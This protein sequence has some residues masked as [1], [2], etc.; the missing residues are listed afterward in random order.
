MEEK[1]LKKRAR[2]VETKWWSESEV[3]KVLD[4]MLEQYKNLKVIFLLFVNFLQR[5]FKIKGGH[6]SRLANLQI[7][8]FCNAIEYPKCIPLKLNTNTNIY[9]LLV[10]SFIL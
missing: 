5:Y 9:V 2:G 1:R 8:H 3:N 10:F 7:L 6:N 4:Y